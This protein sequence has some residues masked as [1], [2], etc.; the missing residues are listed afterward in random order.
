[1]L[2]PDHDT[3]GM[4]T[5]LD[6]HTPTNLYQRYRR[7]RERRAAYNMPFQMYARRAC[8][9]MQIL[10]QAART[11]YG[12][13]RQVIYWLKQDFL[14]A[15]HAHG[16]LQNVSAQQQILKCNT[17]DRG[18]WHRGFWNEDVCYKCGGTGVH[19]RVRLFLFAVSFGA[20]TDF[21]TF[22]FHQPDALAQWAMPLL[23]TAEAATPVE[24]LS[25]YKENRDA[26]R[27]H[28][29]PREL[30]FHLL[31][32]AVYVEHSSITLP[33]ALSNWKRALAHDA[34]EIPN[35]VW[36]RAARKIWWS[37]QALYWR[38]RELV[39]PNT[40]QDELPF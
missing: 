34:M 19:K 12:D 2:I 40:E 6:L 29:S 37:L 24:K 1:M 10:N 20:F 21:K 36:R 5:R 33:F 4:Y 22:E 28:L 35:Y 26:P 14:R 32:V 8:T 27:M 18:I 16:Y 30:Q 17:C 23:D 38:V 9:S 3:F 31:R 7:W 39:R 13:Y 25:R 11:M 15:M